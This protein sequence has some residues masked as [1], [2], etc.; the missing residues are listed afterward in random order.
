MP[1]NKYTNK[2]KYVA[3]NTLIEEMKKDKEV[4]IYVLK[5]IIKYYFKLTPADFRGGKSELLNFLADKVTFNEA[6]VIHNGKNNIQ[7]AG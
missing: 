3:Y 5:E 2:G 6:E 1:F 4:K 7:V